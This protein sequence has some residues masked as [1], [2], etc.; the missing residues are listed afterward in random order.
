MGA[1]NRRQESV[2]KDIAAGGY[3]IVIA[4]SAFQMLAFIQSEHVSHL[5]QKES[6]KVRSFVRGEAD[7]NGKS[8]KPDRRPQIRVEE[9]LQGRIAHPSYF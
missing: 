4:P 8:R 3:R 1:V 7:G 2:F 5:A 9:E 6:Q